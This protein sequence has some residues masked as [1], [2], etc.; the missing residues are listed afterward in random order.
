MFYDIIIGFRDSNSATSNPMKIFS[1]FLAIIFVSSCSTNHDTNYKDQEQDKKLLNTNIIEH[2]K[3]K[4]FLPLE[5]NDFKIQIYIEY[6]NHN[7][8]NYEIVTRLIQMA[9]FEKEHTSKIAIEIINLNDLDNFSKEEFINSNNK[10]I[11]KIFYDTGSSH[12][13]DILSNMLK[14][15]NLSN[16]TYRGQ[17]ETNVPIFIVTENFS[18]IQSLEILNYSIFHNNIYYIFEEEKERYK[19]FGNYINEKYHDR[20]VFILASSRNEIQKSLLTLENAL[21]VPI[22]D[23]YFYYNQRFDY[24]IQEVVS[25]MKRY[26]DL[27]TNP[28]N[29]KYIENYSQLLVFLNENSDQNFC[30]NSRKHIEIVTLYD[31][32]IMLNCDLKNVNI[33]SMSDIQNNFDN[34]GTR[35][36][37]LYDTKI[38]KNKLLVEIYDILSVLLMNIDEKYSLD[39][40]IHSINNLFLNKDFTG[41]L[42]QKHFGDNRIL[43][44]NYKFQQIKEEEKILNY[45][46]NS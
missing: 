3:K 1:L 36:H 2:T 37:Y 18:Q 8:K 32:Q 28:D 20:D 35:Y 41:V 43:H 25:S 34:F 11:A 26:F 38:P 31:M 23:T 5:M 7:K 46:N 6:D 27:F 4:D 45:N 17:T 40:N 14:N 30:L 21:N 10:L 12:S 33:I 29:E 44:R 9:L 15:Q 24:T 39:K 42:G 13:F 19:Q 22:R 16:K